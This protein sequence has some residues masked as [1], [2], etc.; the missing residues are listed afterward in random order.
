MEPGTYTFTID[1]KTPSAPGIDQVTVSTTV[2][3]TLTDPCE[4]QVLT[5]P[6]I[7]PSAYAYTISDTSQIDNVLP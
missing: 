1:G 7:S 4:G 2:T 6:A 5:L 3:W